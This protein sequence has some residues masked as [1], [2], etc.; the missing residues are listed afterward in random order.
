MCLRVDTGSSWAQPSS[1]T[2]AIREAPHDETVGQRQ[3]RKPP[4]PSVR[5]QQFRQ[6]RVPEVRV[7]RSPADMAQQRVL[8]SSSADVGGPRHSRGEGHPRC[9]ERISCSPGH[10][11]GVQLEQCQQF[12]AR[13]EKRVAASDAARIQGIGRWEEG[14]ANLERLLQILHQRWKQLRL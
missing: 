12:V 4:S 2:M 8:K 10:P 5:T 9:S 13:S 6:A 1:S 3:E 11:V 14:K 7:H